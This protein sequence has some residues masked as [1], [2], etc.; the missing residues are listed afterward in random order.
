MGEWGT[1]TT[2]SRM[3]SGSSLWC[4]RNINA[5][6]RE[7]HLVH[8][9][10][11]FFGSTHLL[12]GTYRGP[13]LPSKVALLEFNMMVIRASAVD[14][15]LLRELQ[16]QQR[17]FQIFRPTLS[18]VITLELI[19]MPHSIAAIRKEKGRIVSFRKRRQAYG[20][21]PLPGISS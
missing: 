1:I 9:A 19:I 10:R 15:Q 6:L 5:S 2:T 20:L 11:K 4:H 21:I 14:T 13:L 3:G 8:R 17:S 12:N 7:T 16:G 18:R